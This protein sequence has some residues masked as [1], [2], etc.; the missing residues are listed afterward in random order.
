MNVLLVDDDRTTRILL[1][2][3]LRREG[4][5]VFPTENGRDAYELHCR[6]NVHLVI[7][8]WNMPRMDGLEL[9][10]RLRA[11]RANAY[12]YFILIT[13]TNLSRGSCE[14]ALGDGV[15]DFLMK[16]LDFVQVGLRL[17]AA[18]RVLSYANRLRELESVIPICAHCRRLRD[19]RDA[20]LPMEEYFAKRAAVQFSHGVCPDCARE[21]YPELSGRPS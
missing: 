3:A 5:T 20:Y 14:R 2:A 4:W 18:R 13:A 16:P 15:D 9:C 21:H 17:H 19:D 11:S 8:D 1:E 7:S 6:E 10:R 12:T